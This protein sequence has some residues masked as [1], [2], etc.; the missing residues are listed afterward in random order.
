MNKDWMLKTLTCL[1]FTEMEAQLYIYL[2]YE[3]PKETMRIAEAIKIPKPKLYHGLQKLKN[4]GIVSSS[5]EPPA[6]YSAVNF[7]AI[8]DCLIKTKL[9]EAQKIE[10]QKKE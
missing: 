8:L 5:R 3:G 6:K 4:K 10:R 9:K 7:D 1:G 2:S